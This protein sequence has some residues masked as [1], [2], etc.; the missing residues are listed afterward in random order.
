MSSRCA[1][2]FPLSTIRLL[3]AAVLLTLTGTAVLTLTHTATE[4][5][6]LKADPFY[7]VIVT[8]AHGNPINTTCVPSP[9][10]LT[11]TQA[12]GT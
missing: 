5:G 7:C 3:V 9:F 12:V 6:Q 4:A 2:P 1:I 10:P 8:D 11:G